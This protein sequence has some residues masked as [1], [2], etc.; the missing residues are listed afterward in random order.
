MWRELLSVGKLIINE[1]VAA[2]EVGYIIVSSPFRYGARNQV[3]TFTMSAA[4]GGANETRVTITAKD[5]AGN[6]VEGVVNFDLWL[7]DAAT[8][9]GHTATTASGAV[10][11]HT[12]SGTVVDTQVAKKALRVQTLATGVFVLTIT[13]TA[14]TAF[15]VV[16]QEPA[17]GQAVVGV[18]LATASYG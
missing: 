14:K 13:D 5:A 15:K 16:A 3:A 4:A 8:G 2:T 11:A 6:T 10:T 17:T 18:T 9:A 12:A 7:S 1:I